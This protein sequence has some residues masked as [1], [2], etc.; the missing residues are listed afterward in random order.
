MK[1]GRWLG[2][3][4]VSWTEDKLLGL[5]DARFVEFDIGHAYRPVANDRWNALVKYGYFYDLV[6]TGQ[7]AVRPDQRV[8]ILS[9]EALYRLNRNWE[10]GGKIAVK[11]GRMRTFRDT[12]KWHDSGVMLAVLRARRHIANE[13]DALAEYRLLRDRHGDNRRHGALIGIYRNFGEQQIEMG[14]GYN[15]TNFSDDIR[16]ARYD[17][18]GWFIDL[19][20]KF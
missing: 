20:G 1:I 11:E 12:G 7:D 3:L 9:A 13:W 18:R 14:V 16:D 10:I 15:F 19:I 17:R 5:H 6:S 4:N 8:H 2:R